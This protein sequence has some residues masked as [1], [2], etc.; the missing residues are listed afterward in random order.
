MASQVVTC[1][2]GPREYQAPFGE[3]K[4]DSALKNGVSR[5]RE[6]AMGSTSH[7][8]KLSPIT[9]IYG[10]NASVQNYSS[11]RMNMMLRRLSLRLY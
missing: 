1:A 9:Y 7:L 3:L 10:S 11:Q 6:K 2:K 8:A 4:N 5:V